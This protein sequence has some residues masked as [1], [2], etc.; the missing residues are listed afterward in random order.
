MVRRALRFLLVLGIALGIVVGAAQLGR[1]YGVAA[2]AGVFAIGL[3][4]LWLPRGAHKAFRRGNYTR[5]AV[6]Y[7]VLRAVVWDRWTRAS[8]D[9]SLA[10]C[11]LARFDYRTALALLEQVEVEHLSDAAKAVRLNNRAYARARLGEDPDSALRDASEAI[12]MRPQVAGFRHTRGITLLSL[13]RLDEAIREL[14]AVWLRHSLDEDSPLLE[15][16]RCYDLGVAWTRK[17]ELDYAADY[18]DRA[19]RAAPESPWAGRALS[20]LEAANLRAYPVAALSE[21]I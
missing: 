4:I 9:V 7:R 15:A 21:L 17:G 8:V 6:L 10:A 2:G 1:L 20:E 18:F 19:R 13:D 12:Q 16:E 11:A 3:S 14:D 5:A